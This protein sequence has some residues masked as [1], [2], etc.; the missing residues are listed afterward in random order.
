MYGPHINTLNVYT[1]LGSSL[2]SAI[3]KRTGNQGN[4]WKYGQVLVRTVLN[5]QVSLMAG[6]V[7]KHDELHCL[8]F[9]G[10]HVFDEKG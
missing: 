1:K 9:K 3:W 5:Y 2:G 10:G 8:F 6:Y 7:Q 4:R